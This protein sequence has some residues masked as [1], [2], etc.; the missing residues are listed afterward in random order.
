MPEQL[1][2]IKKYPNRRLY[3][4][5][6]SAYITLSDVKDLVLSRENFNVLDAKTGEDITR[7]ILLQIILEEEAAGI[8]LFTTDLLAQMIRF[9]GHAMQGM[10]G[11]Y[12]ETNIKS[13]VDFQKK[14]QDQ[15]QQLYGENSSQMQSDMWSQ[16]MNF[17]GPAMQTMMATYMEQS[18]KMLHQM[19]D[20]L[21]TQTRTLFTSIPLPGF[22]SDAGKQSTDAEK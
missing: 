16:F 14:L 10:L 15:S 21:K 5:K 20:Q 3:D 19:Q 22:P 12:L 1:R 9:Y 4:T 7:A 2:L 13:F 6:T 11:K 8:P 17:Q 18:R